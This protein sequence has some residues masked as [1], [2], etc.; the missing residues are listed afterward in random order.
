MN[1]D[2]ARGDERATFVAP[3]ASVGVDGDDHAILDHD[4]AGHDDVVEHQA[5]PN[6]RRHLA[7][8]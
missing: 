8:T 5:T 7:A 2:E 4:R 1:V 6:L 3:A